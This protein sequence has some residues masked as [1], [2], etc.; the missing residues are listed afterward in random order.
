MG[1]SI[2]AVL[3]ATIFAIS[4]VSNNPPPSA[5]QSLFII[6]APCRHCCLARPSAKGE[7]VK[8]HRV[9]K[10]HAKLLNYS[11]LTVTEVRC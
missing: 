3:L 10:S 5:C 2:L 11:K 1:R 7:G 4:H 8:V 9:N 6:S